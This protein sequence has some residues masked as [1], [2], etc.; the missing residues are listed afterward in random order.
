MVI[1]CEMYYQK[2]DTQKKFLRVR[3]CYTYV[4]G[5]V[6]VSTGSKDR[7]SIA[8]YFKLFGFSFLPVILVTVLTTQIMITCQYQ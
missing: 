3:V 8:L 1:I 6:C 5:D 2:L 7:N 4:T